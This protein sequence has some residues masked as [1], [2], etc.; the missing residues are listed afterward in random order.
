VSILGLHVTPK[1]LLFAVV[2]FLAVRWLM[3]RA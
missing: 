3:R 2:A 1:L